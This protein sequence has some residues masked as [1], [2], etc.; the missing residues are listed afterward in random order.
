MTTSPPAYPRGTR[1]AY[2]ALLALLLALAGW[3]WPAGVPRARAQD[4]TAPP[5]TE[6]P[7][8]IE[9]WQEIT[10]NHF[11]ILYTPGE[12]ATAQEYAGFVDAIYDEVSTLFSH[13]SE[14]PLTLRLYPDEQSYAQ[15]NPLAPKLPGVVAHADFRHREVAVVL[16]ITRRQSPTGVQNN[17]RHELTHIIAAELSNNRLN[18]GFQEG[19]AQYAEEPAS[20][21]DA[22]I[23]LL[24]QAYDQGNLMDWSEFDSRDIVYGNPERS[25]PQTMSVVAFLIE[26]DGFARFRDF[27]TISARSSGYR[28]ALERAYEMSPA[29]LEHEWQTWLPS[30]L[31]GGYRHTALSAYDLSYANQLLQLGRYAEAETELE[32]A[33]EWLQSDQQAV[34]A[35]QDDTERQTRILEA[36]NLLAR[37]QDGQQAEAFAAEARTA[38]LDAD[39]A[40][41]A[42]RIE[43]ARARYARLGDRRQDQVLATYAERAERGQQALG[44]LEQANRMARALQLPQARTAADTAAEEFA[45][46]GDKPRFNE[47]MRL[48]RSLDRN[49]SLAG[50]ALVAV[51]TLG[52]VVGIW[53]RWFLREEEVW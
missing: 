36:Q 27:L 9:N 51:G 20:E 7:S 4:E 45:R 14:T 53:G 41:A 13:R 52:A 32:Q 44:T 8:P 30:Y 16:P 50:L 23:H 33:L 5:P 26:R 18:T 47:A 43:E 38:L 12:E 35:N 24:Q 2:A 21:R 31:E 39:Y 17:V 1:R 19:I 25:Y 42:Q 22:K 6:A 49:Q 11:V 15:V 3:F 10:T 37:S 29:A 28:S 48:R 46:L 40:R 34:P